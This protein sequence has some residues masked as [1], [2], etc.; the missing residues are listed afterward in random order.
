MVNW[1]VSIGSFSCFLSC[2]CSTGVYF[3]YYNLSKLSTID[4]IVSQK[5]SNGEWKCW[6][7]EM[8]E[9]GG[10][11]GGS[12]FVDRVLLHCTKRHKT[13]TIQWR[14]LVPKFNQNTEKVLKKCKFLTLFLTHP[15]WYIILSLYF[16]KV[17]WL[18][19]PAILGHWDV[20]WNVTPLLLGGSNFYFFTDLLVL[21]FLRSNSTNF[22]SREVQVT[23]GNFDLYW[24]IHYGP[25]Q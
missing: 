25:I 9:V 22:S 7:L 21:I 3:E 18:T 10:G 1:V 8:R 24:K 20:K 2:F 4:V 11:R 14:L 12:L 13:K 23:R 6:A 5:L 17:S 15:L 16:L 19:W